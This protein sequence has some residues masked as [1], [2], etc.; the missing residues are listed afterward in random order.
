MI[1]NKAGSTKATGLEEMT[2]SMLLGEEGHQAEYLDKMITYLAQVEKPDIVH[3]SNALLLGLAHRLKRDLDVKVVCSLQDENEWTDHM[4]D[5]YQR[6]IWDLMGEKAHEVD[7]FITAS[8]YY[9]DKSM[10]QMN[11]I[12]LIIGE[13]LMTITI[14]VKLIPIR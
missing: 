4:N 12:L 8:N 10:K 9:K 6:K 3:L 1:A 2:I 14:W 7:M 5:Q 13:V 11:M